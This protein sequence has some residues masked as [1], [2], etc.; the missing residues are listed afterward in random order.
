MLRL[1]AKIYKEKAKDNFLK[2][3]GRR[4]RANIICNAALW[5]CLVELDTG[6]Y[7]LEK[8]VPDARLLV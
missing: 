3:R 5:R 7:Y 8:A 6:A 4:E 2:L 1:D